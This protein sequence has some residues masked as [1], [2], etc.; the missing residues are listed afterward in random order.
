MPPRPLP[1][2]KIA[3]SRVGT[4]DSKISLLGASEVARKRTLMFFIEGLNVHT[5]SGITQVSFLFCGGDW[6]QI[7]VPWFTILGFSLFSQ[8]VL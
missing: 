1:V 3:A 5:A 6:V 4:N 7:Q 2:T 8:D